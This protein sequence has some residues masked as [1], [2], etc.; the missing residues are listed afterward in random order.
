MQPLQFFRELELLG[1]KRIADENVGVGQF[2]RQTIVVR[3]MH[4][5][6]FRP[7]AAES[8]RKHGL[9]A[10]VGERVPDADDEL[11]GGGS[12]ARCWHAG[13]SPRNASDKHFTLRFFGDHWLRREIVSRT[14][15]DVRRTARNGCP[16]VGYGLRAECLIRLFGRGGGES[17]TW[18]GAYRGEPFRNRAERRRRREV[19]RCARRGHCR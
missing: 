19:F 6:H 7:A 4:D 18:G 1:P 11:G 14:Y 16:T 17:A 3:Q 8:F 2:L 9:R 15:K 12:R 5:A 10:P 13:S